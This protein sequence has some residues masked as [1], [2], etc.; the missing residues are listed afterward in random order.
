MRKTTRNLPLNLVPHHS[1]PRELASIAVGPFTYFM[2]H[3]DYLALGI[4]EP[5]GFNG[6][7]EVSFRPL[8]L[9]KQCGPIPLTISDVTEVTRREATRWADAYVSG[10]RYGWALA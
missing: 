5:H 6:G 3:G 9:V 8:P 7:M 1:D 4:C 2:E 10:G